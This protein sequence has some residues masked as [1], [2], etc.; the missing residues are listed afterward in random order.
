MGR[1]RKTGRVKERTLLR[2]LG[3]LIG[4]FILTICV[5]SPPAEF[6]GQPLPGAAPVASATG[7]GR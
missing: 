1:A 7:D 2:I 3:A 6:G 5:V 4:G